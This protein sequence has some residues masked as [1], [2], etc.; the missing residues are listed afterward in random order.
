MLVVN[1]QISGDTLT[2]AHTC[3]CV[4]AHTHTAPMQNIVIHRPDHAA[5]LLVVNC[6]V[7]RSMDTTYLESTVQS[8]DS[9]FA[10]HCPV[11]G[12]SI[13]SQL[14]SL[15]THSICSELSSLWRQSIVVNHPIYGHTLFLVICPV[16]G[17][18]LIVVNC[19]V[20]G[21]NLLWSI[22]QSMDT[23]YF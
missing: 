4:H 13:C 11:Y 18:T 14:S 15:W 2:H 8:V 16:Y 1:S 19:P 10:V 3:T 17:H 7:Y 5:L 9:L 12:L 20:Y 23:L 22:I 6:P 21:D